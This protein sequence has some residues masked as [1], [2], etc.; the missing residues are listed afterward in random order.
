MTTRHG[1]TGGGGDGGGG[2]GDGGG[3]DGDGGGALG[4][5]T[6]GGGDPVDVATSF[7]GRPMSRV[8]PARIRTAAPGSTTTLLA[9]TAVET[10]TKATINRSVAMLTGT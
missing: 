6:V 7:A 5:G 10:A 2:D 3:G 1:T 9:S 4:G 8:A